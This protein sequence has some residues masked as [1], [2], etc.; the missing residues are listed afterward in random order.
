[1]D[2]IAK[3]LDYDPALIPLAEN[4]FHLISVTNALND[5]VVDT[6]IPE[7]NFEQAIQDLKLCMRIHPTHVYPFLTM[8]ELYVAADNDEEALEWL[9]KAIQVDPEIKDRVD[10]FECF[11]PLREYLTYQELFVKQEKPGKSYYDLKMYVEPG[12]MREAFHM[13]SGKAENIRQA[14]LARIKTYSGFYTLLSYGQTIEVQRFTNGILEATVDIH[15]FLKLIVP[16]ELTASFAEDGQYVIRDMQGNSIP[17]NILSDLLF[18]YFAYGEETET[19][20]L[21]D[22]ETKLGPLSGDIILESEEYVGDDG[23]LYNADTVIEDESGEEYTLEEFLNIA[24]A[25]QE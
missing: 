25:E 17:K 21:A 1:V 18:D 5:R 20:F 22:W 7:K 24:K 3:A 13:V 23:N 12:A 19:V 2:D 11:A 6:Y 16:N 9:N 14:I 8:A 10:G 4:A 15:P